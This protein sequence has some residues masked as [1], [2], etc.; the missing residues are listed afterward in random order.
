M[1]LVIWNELAKSLNES[2]YEQKIRIVPRRPLE[3]GEKIRQVVLSGLGRPGLLLNEIFR[4]II[5]VKSGIS[6][7]LMRMQP[8]QL[9]WG[10]F[11]D[12]IPG[13]SE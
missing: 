12:I 8:A 10:S 1:I 4:I 6:T 13:I 11:R 9:I 5:A 7:G 2:E 3:D